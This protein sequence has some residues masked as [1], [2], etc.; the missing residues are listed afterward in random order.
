MRFDKPLYS[1]RLVRRYKRFLADVVLDDGRELTVHC[2]NSG[3]MTSCS[4]PGSRILVSDSGNPKRKL[5]YTWEM[6]RVGRSWVGVNTANPNR[7]LGGFLRR[8]RIPELAAY[9]SV[10]GEVRVDGGAS[11]LDFRLESPPGA[12][13]S[14]PGAAWVEVKNATLRVGEHAAFP[15]AVTLRGR[16]HLRELET[17]VGRGDR[18]VIFYFVGRMDCARLRP[19]DEVDPEYGAALRRA[20]AAGV[21]AMA[22]R[23]RFTRRGIELAGRLPIDL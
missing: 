22:Y 4:K 8:G 23:F 21:E 14:A 15:D 9:G 19:A 3:A 2:A 7:A 18:A 13:G 1:G 12:E 6:I 16:K 20:V 5:R 11:R 17:L 10:R